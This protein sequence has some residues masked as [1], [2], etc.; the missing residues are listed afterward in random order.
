MSNSAILKNATWK[1]CNI[2]WYKIKIVEH[3][4]V[5]HLHSETLKNRTVNSV[6]WKSATQIGQTLK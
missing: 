6:K 2:K 1:Q 4:I 5:L 3:N